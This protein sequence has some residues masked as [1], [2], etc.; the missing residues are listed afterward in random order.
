ML[1]AAPVC[2]SGVASSLGIQ[3]WLLWFFLQWF[4]QPVGSSFSFVL[5]VCPSRLAPGLSSRCFVGV[6]L[7]AGSGCSKSLTCPACSAASFLYDKVLRKHLA[8]FAVCVHLPASISL[9]IHLAVRIWHLLA[10]GTRVWRH[11]WYRGGGGGWRQSAGLMALL[12]TQSKLTQHTLSFLL[13]GFK[14][15][16]YAFHC[17]LCSCRKIF[18]R[19]QFDKMRQ[20]AHQKCGSTPTRS[21]FPL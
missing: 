7:P 9:T 11:R 1:R 21:N 16:Y 2:L 6:V 18:P 19:L 14:Q 10:R 12:L 20:H 3:P 4:Y 17:A 13:V 5:D 8:H 15:F